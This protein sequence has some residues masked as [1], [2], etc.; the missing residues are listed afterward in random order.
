MRNVAHHS[1]TRPT[2]M[3]CKGTLAVCS[4]P[5]ISLLSR[6]RWMHK[7]LKD[8]DTGAE[9]EAMS[10]DVLVVEAMQVAAVAVELA[11]DTT[12]TL[13]RSPRRSKKRRG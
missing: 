7:N 13:K 8:M 4:T 6:F 12:H 10:A 3:S 1:R 5:T 2:R 9:A 11:L